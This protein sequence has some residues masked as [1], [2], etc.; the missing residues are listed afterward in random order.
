[1][2]VRADLDA[3]DLALRFD[4]P[5]LAAAGGLYLAGLVAFGAY[6][7]RVLAASRRRSGPIR[8]SALI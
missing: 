1:M 5:T 7:W 2:R 6:F 3:R 4:P 8:P